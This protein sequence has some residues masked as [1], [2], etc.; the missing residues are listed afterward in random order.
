MQRE[1]HRRVRLTKQQQLELCRM[2]S[3]EPTWSLAILGRWAEKQFALEKAPAKSS[4]KRI[5]E[6]EAALKS[7]PVDFIGLIN[8]PRAS[9]LALD[10]CIVEMVLY[11]EQ[12][13]VPISSRLLMLIGRL[14]ADALHIP[15][16]ERPRFT[17]DGWLK[18]FMR[19]YG[20]RHRRDHGEIGSVDL[21]A[22]RKA[23]LDMRK[24]IAKYDPDDV[25]NMDEAAF[26]SRRRQALAYA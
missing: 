25:Y 3:L 12:R 19:R 1:L 14:Y 6:S 4:V 21:P 17:R 20:L 23:A 8:A 13:H 22:A 11:A 18:H 7:I 24:T 10:S 2:H 15:P 16:T 9:M 26:F 5:V